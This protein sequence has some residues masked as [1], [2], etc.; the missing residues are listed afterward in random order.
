MGK[1]MDLRR[2]RTEVRAALAAYMQAEG[3][4]CCRD[5]DAHEV[6]AADLA[7]LL[8]VPKYDDGSGYDFDRFRRDQKDPDHA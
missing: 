2:F 7:K 4:G 8:R 3:C 6:A 1:P 5:R